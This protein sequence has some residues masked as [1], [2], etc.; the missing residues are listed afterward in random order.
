METQWEVPVEGVS[1]LGSRAAPGDV[2]VQNAR[3][4]ETT[5]GVRAVTH[6]ASEP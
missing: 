6:W 2:T 4:S 3:G 1:A 5:V